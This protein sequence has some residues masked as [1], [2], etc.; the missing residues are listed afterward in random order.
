M[1]KLSSIDNELYFYEMK[2][3]K[4]KK[5]MKYKTMVSCLSVWVTSGLGLTTV[6]QLDRL[7]RNTNDDTCFCFFIFYLFCFCELKEHFILI[8]LENK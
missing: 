6:S 4:P 5:E 1:F 7:Y 3:K 8:K 2:K